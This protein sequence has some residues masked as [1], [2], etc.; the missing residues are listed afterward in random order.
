[1][2]KSLLIIAIQFLF[3]ALVSA[4]IYVGGEV[5]FKSMS[6][7]GVGH[8]ELARQSSDSYTQCDGTMFSFGAFGGLNTV[9]LP[10]YKLDIQL[11]AT[12]G[13]IGFVE[14]GYDF[15]GGPGSFAASG[16]SG[17]TTMVLDMD[18]LFLNRLTLPAL[19]IVEP[20]VG[21]GPAFM[22]YN[23]SSLETT[24]GRI[25]GGLDVLPGLV[26]CYGFEIPIQPQL[27]PYVQLRHLINFSDLHLPLL[28][29]GGQDWYRFVMYKSP[30]YFSVM[31]GVKIV[32]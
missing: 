8:L 12:V 1:M 29:Q 17:A 18:V 21:V 23:T 5:G 16:Q 11:D 3:Y 22:L 20:Y 6:F 26:I 24:N 14:N 7:S 9:S 13:W 4:Q 30:S 31:V 10:L 32:L 2:K 15:H 28:D 25:K 19:N 27:I